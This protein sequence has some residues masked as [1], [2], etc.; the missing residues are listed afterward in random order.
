MRFPRSTKDFDK[1]ASLIMFLC[2]ACIIIFCPLCVVAV[3]DVLPFSSREGKYIPLPQRQREMNRERERAERGPGGPPPHNRL[4]G[5]YRSNP[6]SSSSPRPPLPSGAGP[7]PGVSPSERSSP[8]SGRGGAYA[9]H[10]PQ[11]S[12][13]PGPGSA[14]ANPYTPAS[15]G[16]PAPTLA[17]AS[18]AP[19][20]GSPPAPHGHTVPHSHSLPHSLSDAGRPVNGGKCV[21]LCQ[22]VF[23]QQPCLLL[24]KNCRWTSRSIFSFCVFTVSAR[25]SP[26]AQRPPQSSRTARSTNSHSQS[27]GISCTQTQSPVVMKYSI[28]LLLL[29][30]LLLM[31]FA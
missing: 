31:D 11:G 19:S 27:T 9:P 10:H 29:L 22:T 8:L 1:S 24:S 17:S 3:F 5:G 13:S 14:P 2:K 6:P 21:S 25:T 26:K 28:L 7:Q 18:A 23:S 4:S 12:P 30:L 15:P 20:P 16:G